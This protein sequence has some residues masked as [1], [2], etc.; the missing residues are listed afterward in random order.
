MPVVQNSVY[1]VSINPVNQSKARLIVTTS[2]RDSNIVIIVNYTKN[3]F[4]DIQRP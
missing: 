3:I 2:T 4:A 1:K